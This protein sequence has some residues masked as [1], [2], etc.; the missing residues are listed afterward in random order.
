LHPGY[1]QPLTTRLFLPPTN[2]AAQ[3]PVG[4]NSFAKQAE[5]LPFSHAGDRFAFH[6]D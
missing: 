3:F 5:G 4:A 6:G 1:A 2:R